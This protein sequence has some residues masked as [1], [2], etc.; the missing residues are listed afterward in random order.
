[1]FAMRRILIAVF[2]AG[3]MLV[4]WS[5]A[6]GAGQTHREPVKGISH[7]V[8][9]GE[10]LWSIATDAYPGEDPRDGIRWIQRANDL[11]GGLIRPGMQVIVPA[12]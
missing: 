9:P 8:K 7:L 12:R 5:A 2:L 4:G 1:M 11:H 6:V 3:A 10:T